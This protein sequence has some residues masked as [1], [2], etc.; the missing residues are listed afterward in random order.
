MVKI[1]VGTVEEGFPV[2]PLSSRHD[3]VIQYL[4]PLDKLGNPDLVVGKVKPAA[5]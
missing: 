1:Q 2:A 5:A 4:L 3:P